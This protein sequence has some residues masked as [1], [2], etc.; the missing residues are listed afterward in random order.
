MDGSLREAPHV[1]YLV[2]NLRL[3]LALPG[4]ADE[5]PAVIDG[6]VPGEAMR[7]TLVSRQDAEARLHVGDAVTARFGRANDASYYFSAEVRE[8][9]RGLRLGMVLGWPEAVER[10]QNRRHVRMMARFDVYLG[11]VDDP[12]S[13]ERARSVDVSGG[14][15]GIVGLSALAV[16]DEMRVRCS[17]PRARGLCTIDT[18]ARVVRCGPASETSRGGVLMWRSGLEFMR[19]PI[20]RQDELMATVMWNLARRRVVV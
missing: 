15:I 17:L 11:R 19:M 20:R 2:P 6:M 7:L 13:W 3:G 10:R 14:G 8:L 1:S 4:V 5:R 16:G 12:S 9:R 18:L